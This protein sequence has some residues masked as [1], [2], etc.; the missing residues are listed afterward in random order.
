MTTEQRIT[1][2]EKAAAIA[3]LEGNTEYDNRWDIDWRPHLVDVDGVF[4][5]GELEAIILLK[6]YHI[7]Q[8]G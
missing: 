5:L 6:R 7:Q 3:L 4:T 2:E 1:E 8:Q